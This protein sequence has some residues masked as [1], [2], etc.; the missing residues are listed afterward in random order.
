MR[1]GARQRSVRN[2]RKG[3]QLS[4]RLYLCLIL[5]LFIHPRVGERI[6]PSDGDSNGLLSYPSFSLLLLL[7]LYSRDIPACREHG[8]EEEEEEEM[9]DLCPLRNKL[10]HAS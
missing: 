7:S 5:H 2:V 10:W 9:M 4:L 3:H 6:V 8:G 1:Q